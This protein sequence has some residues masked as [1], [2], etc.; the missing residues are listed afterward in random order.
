[1]GSITVSMEDIA[2]DVELKQWELNNQ[3]RSEPVKYALGDEGYGPE[4][5]ANDDC[6]AEMPAARRAHGFRICVGCKSIEEGRSKH[7]RRY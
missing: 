4:F 2:Q 1:M 3:S 6:G 5:C 7:L